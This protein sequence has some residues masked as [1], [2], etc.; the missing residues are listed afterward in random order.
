M[1]PEERR[2]FEKR[3]FSPCE[4]AAYACVSRTT[5]DDWISKGELPCEEL[6]SRGTTG[7]RLRRIRKEDLDAFL[8]RSYTN[9]QTKTSSNNKQKRELILLPRDA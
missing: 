8:D 1:L 6:P 7:K 5:L 3:A 2:K 9:S 4:A